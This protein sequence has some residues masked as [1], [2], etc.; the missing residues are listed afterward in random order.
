MPELLELAAMA[1]ETASKEGAEFADVVVHRGK[2]MSVELEKGSVKSSDMH[3]R[4]DVSVRAF[5]KGGTGWANTSGLGEKDVTAAA[6]NAATLAKIAQP[7]PDFVSL[8]RPATYQEVEGLYDP[9]IAEL[10]IQQVIAY[11]VMNIDAAR[12]VADDVIVAGGASTGVGEYALVNSLGVQATRRGTWISVSIFSIIKRGDDV[13]SFFEFDQART[14]A[15]FTAEGIGI[16][17]TEIALQFLGSRKVETKT[18][19]VVFGPLASRGIFW[20]VCANANAEDIQRN[21]SYLVGKRGEKIASDIVTITDNALIPRGMSSSS[22]DGEGFPA[23][24]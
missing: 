5:V 22:F 4:T 15:D 21:R 14:L 3:W 6:K 1:C 2:N 12:E 17:A 10:D 11:A 23:S 16:K 8:P 7:D 20:A 9:K 19:P 13:G 24:L 18:L